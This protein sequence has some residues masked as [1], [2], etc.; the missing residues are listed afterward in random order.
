MA[1]CISTL[2]PN[3]NADPNIPYSSQIETL[4]GGVHDILFWVNK[5]NPRGP[6]PQYPQDD[7]QFA[8]WEY[9]VHIW[10]AQNGYQ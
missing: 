5:D 4:S 6:A 7:E 8:R 10:A 9:S 1:R 2:T 3:P